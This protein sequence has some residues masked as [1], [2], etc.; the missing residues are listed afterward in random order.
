MTL[1]FVE[2]NIQKE[3]RGARKLDKVLTTLR[4][5]VF[6]PIHEETSDGIDNNV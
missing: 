1:L 6:I 2:T 3:A 5:L 4:G